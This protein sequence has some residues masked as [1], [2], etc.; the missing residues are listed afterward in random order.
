MESSRS[1]Y[2]QRHRGGGDGVQQNMGKY[3]SVA[4]SGGGTP[5]QYTRPPPPL[6]GVQ[7]LPSTNHCSVSVI[8]D[9][10]VSAKQKGKELKEK[11]PMCLVNELARFN[12]IEHHYKLTDETGPAH[13]KS[14][15]VCLKIGDKE[16]YIASGAS[17]KK[18]QH[19]GAAIALEKTQYKHPTPKVKNTNTKMVTPTV[20]L[21]GL[22]MKIGEVPEYSIVRRT[23]SP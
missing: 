23:R 7:L 19:A 10:C 21:N 13:K 11:T 15:T 18:A 14:F 9:V 16:E 17:I 3:R 8:A 1:S 5:G 2:Q 22:A 6:V 4:G 12:K 20:E